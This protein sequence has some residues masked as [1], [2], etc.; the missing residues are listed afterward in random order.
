MRSTPSSALFWLTLSAT[1]LWVVPA[2]VWGQGSQ[3]PSENFKQFSG[4]AVAA[5]RA[6]RSEEA[7]RLY[8]RALQVKPEWPDGW[9]NVGML[10][11]DRREFTR[12]E[13]AFRNLLDLEP[14]NGAGWALLGL[15]EFERG[16]YDDAY[17]HLRRGRSLGVGTRDL[18]TVSLYHAALIM[19][20]K[21]EFEVAQKLLKWPAAYGVSDADIITAFGM[22]A[23]RIP[24][25]P[26]KLNPAQ[27]NLT[28]RV[29]EIC[30]RSTR[31]RFD[32]V[33][34]A[35]EQLL[36]E[37]PNTP[38]LHY[39]YGDFLIHTGHYPQGF[40][41]MNRELALDPNH[42]MAL[43]QVALTHVR[44][45]DPARALPFAEKAARLAPQHFASHYVLGWTLLKLGK[46]EESIP[47]LERALRM[48]P[49]SP[50]L[51]FALSQAYLRVGRKK[52]AAREQREFARL[53]SS[54]ASAPGAV[55]APAEDLPARPE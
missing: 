10:L 1:L 5:Q 16:R 14:K 32:E 54:S 36:S 27:K 41:E 35:Y 23:L 12:A 29:G 11:A 50:Q 38:G 9:R 24:S 42:F 37:L 30:L 22:A 39:A 7:I 51:H 34:A 55:P 40:E 4:Q 47:E 18:E 48:G 43:M 6:G 49:R 53:S 2:S 17:S 3:S 31:A 44:L 45:G 15:C 46:A 13:A 20:L 28:R 26:E 21:G 52:D 33:S 25:L 8:L 19:I